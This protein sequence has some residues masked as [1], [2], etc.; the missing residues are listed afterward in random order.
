[1]GGVDEAE[2]DGAGREETA[3]AQN[4]GEQ[5]N[6]SLTDQGTEE[7]QSPKEPL[8]NGPSVD[9]E[10]KKDDKNMDTEEDENNGENG[11]NMDC[12]EESA[13]GESVDKENDEN[14]EQSEKETE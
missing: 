14:T 10:E 4:G 7:N 12:L 9:E 3:P 5:D 6:P 1:M 2:D 11:E 13:E 8:A